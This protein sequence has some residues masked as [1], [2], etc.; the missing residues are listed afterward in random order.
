[1]EKIIVQPLHLQGEGEYEHL[2]LLGAW[3][4]LAMLIGSLGKFHKLRFSKIL[5]FLTL[6]LEIVVF[7]TVVL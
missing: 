3:L 7:S 6:A 1:M 4:G 5:L 2:P